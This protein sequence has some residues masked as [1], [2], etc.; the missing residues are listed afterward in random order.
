MAGRR[1]RI[2]LAYPELRLAIECDGFRWHAQRSDW[3]ADRRRQNDLVAQGWR[4]LRLTAAMS[5]DE[6]IAAIRSL[7]CE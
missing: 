4:V 5:D 3:D 6:I 1:Y 2:D 7:V